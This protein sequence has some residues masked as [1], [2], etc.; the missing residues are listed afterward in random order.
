MCATEIYL[1]ELKNILVIQAVLYVEGF[2][3]D[4]PILVY[5]IE[6]LYA[7]SL[8]AVCATWDIFF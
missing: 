1:F 2:T 4:I 5:D 8:E 7:A 6:R 3:G